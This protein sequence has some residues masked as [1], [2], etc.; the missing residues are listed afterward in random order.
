MQMLFPAAIIANSIGC[1]VYYSVQGPETHLSQFSLNVR[2]EN[3]PADYSLRQWSHFLGQL[4]YSA[5]QQFKM[6]F[7]LGR[8]LEAYRNSPK[9]I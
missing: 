6:I 4:L 5:Q 1:R 2:H 7:V 8:M 3:Q 9:Q